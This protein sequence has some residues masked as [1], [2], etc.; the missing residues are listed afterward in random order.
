MHVCMHRDSLQRKRILI[1][2]GPTREHLD[3]VRFI[4]NASSGRMGLALAECAAQGG[5]DVA[6]VTGPV[7]EARLP[8][9]RGIRVLRVESAEE[10]LEAGRDIFP[11]ADI[12]VFA[13]AVAD[14]KPAETADHKVPKKSAGRVIRL[15]ATVDVAASLCSTKRAD[16]V[17]IGFALQTGRDEAAARQKLESKR[18]DGIVLN[19][20]DALGGPTGTYA[21]LAAGARDFEIWGHCSKEK[22]AARIFAAARA[23]EAR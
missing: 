12:A 5:A 8:R 1:T 20:I 10:M 6:F 13:A 16:Q 18:L 11:T 14:Y 17:A 3:P 22:C 15:L 21:Y 2:S 7:D 4:S 9:G 23:V 19:A